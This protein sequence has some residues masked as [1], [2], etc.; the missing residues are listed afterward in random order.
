L[1]R[2][3][4]IRCEESWNSPEKIMERALQIARQR[5][6][7]AER[8]IMGLE[9]KNETLEIALNESIKFY[10]VAKYNATFGMGWNLRQCQDTG[11]GL[12]AFCRANSIE[13]R[14]C[15]TGDERFGD[16]N[17]YPLTAWEAFM[18]SRV[19]A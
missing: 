5:A 8:R 9:E 10:T 15:M 2:E 11:K 12:T 6:L 1:F 18:A 4:F 3:Y 7:E 16:V 19:C 14:R 13:I 17:S